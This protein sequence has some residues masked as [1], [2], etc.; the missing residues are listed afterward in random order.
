MKFLEFITKDWS[1]YILGK[2]SFHLYE[3]EQKKH[4]QR[5]LSEKNRITKNNRIIV[6]VNSD[7]IY[8]SKKDGEMSDQLYLALLSY[9]LMDSIKNKSSKNAP[10]NY[11]ITPTISSMP[12]IFNDTSDSADAL[13]TC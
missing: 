2:I 1:E 9:G 3:N 6:K 10:I 4:R 11:T 13:E 5:M 8:D 7:I 12:M